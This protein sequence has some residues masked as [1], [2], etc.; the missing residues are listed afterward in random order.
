M[1]A[2]GILMSVFGG[3]FIVFSVN[4]A[5][6]HQFEHPYGWEHTL[7]CAALGLLVCAAGWKLA[8]SRKSTS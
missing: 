4:E 3:L 2:I 7:G 8:N 6:S 1:K 5:R